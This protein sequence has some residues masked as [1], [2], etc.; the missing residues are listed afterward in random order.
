MVVSVVCGC[1]ESTCILFIFDRDLPLKLNEFP[2]LDNDV[3]MI[4]PV[5]VASPDI[6]AF[7]LT[8][9]LPV[10]NVP[11]ITFATFDRVLLSMFIVAPLGF[12]MIGVF[13]R[14]E[15]TGP[16]ETLLFTI[17]PVELIRPQTS[18]PVPA[19]RDVAVTPP[20]LVRPWPLKFI[21]VAL[22]AATMST[23]TVLVATVLIPIRFLE[24]TWISLDGLLMPTRDTVPVVNTSPLTSSV[25]VGLVV[26]IPILFATVIVPVSLT[27]KT[28]N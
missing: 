24:F 26:L 10:C 15:V 12:E 11:D 5:I 20:T 16:V 13:M 28:G 27:E 8:V 14:V 22:D 18:V 17:E 7:W 4:V 3:A 21:L 2:S 25:A 1:I 9:T 19:F 23:I 6:V